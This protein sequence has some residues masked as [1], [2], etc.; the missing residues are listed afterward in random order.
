MIQLRGLTSKKEI[1]SEEQLGICDLYCMNKPSIEI[2]DKYK[3]SGKTPMTS[4]VIST[5]KGK[6]WVPNTDSGGM[7]PYLS[8]IDEIDERYLD[9]DV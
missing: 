3:L 6:N 9:K 5:M 8:Q 2:V 4:A 7:D 1:L